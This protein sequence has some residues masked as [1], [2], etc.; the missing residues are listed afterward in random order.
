M[1]LIIIDHK[2][3]ASVERF[4]TKLEKYFPEH[5]VFAFDSLDKK[6]RET[7]MDLVKKTGCDSAHEFLAAYGYEIITGDAVKKLRNTVIYT[8]GNEPEIIKNKVNNLVNK[9]REYYPDGVVSNLTVE[10]KNMSKTLSG[11]YQWLGYADSTKMLEA[12]GFVVSNNAGGRPSNDYQGLVDTLLERY[13]TKEKVSSIALLIHDNPD[14]AGNI[15]TLQNKAKELFGKTISD[16]FKEVGILHVEEKVEKIVPE[17]VYHYLEVEVDDKIVYCATTSKTIKV[18]EYVEM[19]SLFDQDN[20]IGKVVKTC[21]FT[22]EKDLP[23]CTKEMLQLIRKLNKTETKTYLASFTEYIYCL[24][25]LEEVDHP[26]YYLSDFVDISVNDVV[27]VPYSYYG[28]YEGIVKRV[29]RFHENEVPVPIKR[30]KKIQK[31]TYSAATEK[32]YTVDE[33]NAFY[34]KCDVREFVKEDMD[35]HALDTIAYFASCVFRGTNDVVY[36]ALRYMYPNDKSVAKYVK[37]LVSGISQFECKSSKV[38]EVLDKFPSLKG[39]FFAECW[40]DTNVYL[41]YSES[42]YPMVTSMRFI[43]TCD[44]YTKDRWTLMKD[45]CEY[46]E[47]ERDFWESCTYVKD[48]KQYF[49]DQRIESSAYVKKSIFAPCEI[50][51]L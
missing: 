48:G 24:I 16:Y 1:G 34:N 29:E 44:F 18:D 11:L 25:Q 8:P 2:V 35:M 14:L 36:E 5:K 50:I 7:M 3:E 19:V 43:D 33:V 10:H 32:R 22:L 17:K 31:I 26:L 4:F 42:G 30:M 28:R 41:A 21:Y 15:K 9:L 40:R 12:Y 23:C 20:K 6:L 46:L 37:H 13:Q 38:L 51:K 27:M 49:N 47:E 39:I 45:P